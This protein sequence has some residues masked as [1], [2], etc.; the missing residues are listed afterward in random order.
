MQA[1][2]VARVQRRRG[3]SGWAENSPTRVQPRRD[4]GRTQPER[5]GDFVAPEAL[6]LPPPQLTKEVISLSEVYD[7][8]LLE[9]A[10]GSEASELEVPA[11]V[12]E[13]NYV[14]PLRD[15]PRRSAF[16]LRADGSYSGFIDENNQIFRC[17]A[18][19]AYWALLTEL[20]R[21]NHRGNRK[22]PLQGG[23]RWSIVTLNRVTESAPASI[24]NPTA[25]VTFWCNGAMEVFFQMQRF[26]GQI[27]DDFLRVDCWAVQDGWEAVVA[28]SV[29]RYPAAASRYA[30]GMVLQSE[31]HVAL[32]GV[33][34][35]DLDV[36]RPI[37]IDEVRLL[38]SGAQQHFGHLVRQ[39][40]SESSPPAVPCV[41]WQ[42]RLGPSRGAPC[43]RPDLVSM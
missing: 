12:L 27:R 24:L 20:P 5:F 1:R 19:T 37:K 26:A 16:G 25:S 8:P 11:S 21:R 7:K 9:L 43:P 33:N 10:E 15:A 30:P 18:Q 42:L 4:S 39:T 40:S 13:F 34:L 17:G 35:L 32:R 6:R 38:P 29:L 36:S 14:H 22:R 31:D 23:P 41:E 3:G 28:S 2:N